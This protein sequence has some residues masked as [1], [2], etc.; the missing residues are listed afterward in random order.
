MARCPSTRNL[1]IHHLRRDG[2]NDIANAQVL[3]QPCHSKTASYG[4]PGK[5]PP[6][7]DQATKDRALRRA[8]N[9]CECARG[10]C[11]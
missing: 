11:H 6:E 8:G 10:G 2:G 7:F 4:A 1:E 3:C 5:S 9:Q